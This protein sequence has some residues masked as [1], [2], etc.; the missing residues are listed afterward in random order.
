MRAHVILRRAVVGILLA[1]CSSSALAVDPLTLILLR[2][3]RDHIISAA[4]EGAYNRLTAPT[5]PGPLVFPAHP[6]DL[7]DA[8]L[9][10]LIDEGF[11]HLTAAQREEVF[12]SVK[13]ILADP[14]NAAMRLQIIEELSLKA[15]AVRQAHAQLN[16]LSRDRKRLIATEAREEYRKLKPEERHQMLTLVQSGVVPIPRDLNDMILTEFRS[17]PAR[18]AAAPAGSPEASP[19]ASAPA[20][21]EPGAQR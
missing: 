13:R 21:P 3:L 18:D 7:D 8:R 12:A 17:V 20:V 5:P 16:N 9:R 15:S 2:F 14:R 10:T 4:A 19:A 6:Y 1:I 11:V